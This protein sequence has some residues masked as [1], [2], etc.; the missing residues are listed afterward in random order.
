MIKRLRELKLLV[1]FYA[2]ISLWQLL[3]VLPLKRFVKKSNPIFIIPP[4]LQTVWESRGDEAMLEVIM[5]NYKEKKMLNYVIFASSRVKRIDDTHMNCKYFHKWFSRFPMLG[6]FQA[7]YKIRP[8]E[9][10]IVGA[11]CMDGYYSRLSSLTRLICI[12]LC[13]RHA[14]PYNII[15]FSF[16]Q[17]PNKHLL[18]PYKIASKKIVFKL[19]DP[20]SLKR[21]EQFTNRKPIQVADSAFLLQANGNSEDLVSIESQINSLKSAYEFA[22]GFNFHPMLLKNITIEELEYAVKTIANILI[23][24]LMLHPNMCVVIIPHDNR[25]KNSDIRALNLIFDNLKNSDFAHR[26]LYIDKVYH[27]KQIKYIAGLLD[28]L[29]CSRMHL[30]IAALGMGIPVLTANYQGKFSGLFQ[31]F[32]LSSKY[33]LEYNEFCSHI[34]V[35]RFN[36]FYAEYENIKKTIAENKNSVFTLALRNFTN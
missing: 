22:I 16:N 30:A 25:G 17:S 2:N 15:G 20:V 9:I 12:D 19:R 13:E 10:I 35:E 32:H 4:D 7:L 26:I 28:M 36:E 5:D 1:I 21:F 3:K 23:E 6:F 18:L 29:I 14:I 31:L 11:D 27:A 33:I 8:S 24:I 34:L